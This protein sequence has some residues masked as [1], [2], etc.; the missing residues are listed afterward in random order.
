VDCI[1]EWPGL[2]GEFPL[3]GF[4]ASHTTVTPPPA[5]RSMPCWAQSFWHG[6]FIV[7]DH[8]P[9]ALIASG[10]G[11]ETALSTAGRLFWDRLGDEE[12]VRGA[13]TVIGRP[14]LWEVPPASDKKPR[15]VGPAS[16]RELE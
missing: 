8:L 10:L 9:V 14:R 3:E 6:D 16:A 15:R 4:L 1:K 5:A 12:H 11:S 7:V 13:R 2:G